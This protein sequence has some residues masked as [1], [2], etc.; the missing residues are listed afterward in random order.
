MLRLIA[1]IWAKLGYLFALEVEAAK[2]DIN[3]RIASQNAVAAA[4]LELQLRSDADAIE[5]SIKK[6]EA[7]EEARKSAPEYLKLTPQEQYEDERAAKAE[8]D[9]ALQM[10]AEKRKLA[11]QERQN[12]A[13]RNQVAETLSGTAANARQFANKIRNL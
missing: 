13:D 9:A 6:V 8:K 2:G 11:D 3:S 10:V 5:A 12:T 1:R 4:Q 7:E